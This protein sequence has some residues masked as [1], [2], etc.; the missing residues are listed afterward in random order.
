MSSSP[1]SQLLNQSAFRNSKQF[2]R[3]SGVT[4]GALGRGDNFCAPGMFSRALGEGVAFADWIKH[5]LLA[6]MVNVRARSAMR[7][8]QIII[9]LKP[10]HYQELERLS[11]VA[12]S[13]SVSIF[14]KERILASLGIGGGAAG[15]NLAGN[16]NISAVTADIRRLHRDLQVF[17]AE[18]LSGRDFGYVPPE[19]GG[20]AAAENHE[21]RNHQE[22]DESKEYKDDKADKDDETS[23]IA[24]GDDFIDP[25]ELSPS[26][27]VSVPK[28]PNVSTSRG[29]NV[30]P[31]EAS[32]SPSTQSNRSGKAGSGSIGPSASSFP[33]SNFYG[34]KGAQPNLHFPILASQ[35]SS[36]SGSSTPAKEV[37]PVRDASVPDDLEELAERAFA[38]SPRLGAID[39]VDDDTPM[40]SDPLDELLGEMDD[41][42]LP[43]AAH[44]DLQAVADDTVADDREKAHDSANRATAGE[45]A[46][47][48]S[49][50]K[51]IDESSSSSASSAR[52]AYGADEADT[53]TAAGSDEVD[54]SDGQTRTRQN[55]SDGSSSQNPPPLSGGP[56]P[57]RRRT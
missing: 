49:L 22:N 12:G 10:E 18:S 16:A 34:Q 26:D 31:N 4:Y 27:N 9:N 52:D 39:E 36:G 14:V 20:S 15:A 44:Q 46:S 56:P 51:G 53:Q 7:E 6:K 2:L 8:H 54:S 11:R 17:V 33:V 35:G 13:R 30:E 38:I 21:R 47:M 57:R 24:L 43:A 40:F 25:D 32:Q 19:S 50:A 45:N 55:A 1:T 28:R 42:E 48:E 5:S 23:P 37:N 41:D 3:T 29:A